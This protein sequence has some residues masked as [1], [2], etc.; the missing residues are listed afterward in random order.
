MDSDYTHVIQSTT[1]MTYLLGRTNVPDP[2]NLRPTREQML[3]YQL[4]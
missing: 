2:D 3:S 4:V 1:S